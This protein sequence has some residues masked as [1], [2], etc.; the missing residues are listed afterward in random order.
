MGIVRDTIERLDGQVRILRGRIGTAV[1]LD[2][3]MERE[4]RLAASP[5]AWVIPGRLTGGPADDLVGAFRQSV[6]RQVSVILAMRARD[7]TGGVEAVDLEDLIEQ[8]S[9]ALIG[10]EP[11]GIAQSARGTM[12]LARGDLIALRS[13]IIIYALDF[14]IEDEWRQP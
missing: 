8:V 14:S 3:L 6:S 11:P 5:W 1:D 13:G 7:A 4:V 10:Y 2:A 12:K 9:E